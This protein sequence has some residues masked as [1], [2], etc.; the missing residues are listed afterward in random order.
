MA[1]E[2]QAA[3]EA[4]DEAADVI[5]A[6]L[7]MSPA[8]LEGALEEIF[9]S[10]DVDGNGVLDQAEFARC[11]SKIGGKLNLPKSVVRD[12]FQQVDVNGDG[13][14]EWQEFVG[15][16][17]HIIVGSLTANAAAQ[18]AANSL[19][20]DEEMEAAQRQEEDQKWRLDHGFA[21]DSSVTDDEIKA[22]KL[23]EK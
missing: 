5:M 10:A 4:V 12:I 1:G 6:V 21:A 3:A 17:V 8:Q 18:A 19:M 23:K 13:V 11:I 7:G 22:I 20:T 14:V 2:A 16:A 15:P 9:R